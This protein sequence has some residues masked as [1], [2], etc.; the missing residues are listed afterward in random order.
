MLE[1]FVA[2]DGDAAACG[3]VAAARAADVDGLAG[4]DSS[5]G[6]AHVHGVGV[7]D[8]GHGL[9]VGAHVGGGNVFFRADEFDQL[10]GVT[11]GHPFEFALRHLLWD[12]R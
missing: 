6:L 3:L 4:D 8:P 1:R 11:A 12:R 2:D 9:L 5:D 7:H 10:G